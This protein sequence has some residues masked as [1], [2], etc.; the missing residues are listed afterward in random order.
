M[1]VILLGCTFIY[2]HTPL[3]SCLAIVRKAALKIVSDIQGFWT[4]I[5]F[6]APF[7]AP[8]FTRQVAEVFCSTN[9][10]D[11]APIAR[12]RFPNWTKFLTT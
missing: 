8:P 3:L 9:M 2:T 12:K 11:V 7:L 10:D 1:K 5:N 4:S 6:H